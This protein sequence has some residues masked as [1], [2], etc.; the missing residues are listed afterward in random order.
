MIIRQEDVNDYKEIYELVKSAFAS[1]E[2]SE[3]KRGQVP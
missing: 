2:I 3:N 1:A